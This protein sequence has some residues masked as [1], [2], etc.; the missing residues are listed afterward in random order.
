MLLDQYKK[1][2]MK[3][4]YY[5]YFYLSCLTTS[6]ALNVMLVRKHFKRNVYQVKLNNHWIDKVVKMVMS[7]Y[8]SPLLV[9]QLDF[10]YGIKKKKNR[11]VKKG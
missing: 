4:V 3:I 9:R 8:K 1:Y 11:Q 10:S 2:Y 6:I 7:M 5:F